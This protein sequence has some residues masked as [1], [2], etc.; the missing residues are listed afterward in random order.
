M[1][2]L[3]FYLAGGTSTGGI[4]D[5]QPLKISPRPPKANNRRGYPVSDAFPVPQAQTGRRAALFREQR[6]P[7]EQLL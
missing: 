7:A 3:F 5:G 6:L 2:I 4:P 1:F